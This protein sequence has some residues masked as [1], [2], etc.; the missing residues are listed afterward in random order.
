M[1]HEH[2]IRLHPL[3]RYYAGYIVKREQFNRQR[4][5]FAIGQR[6]DAL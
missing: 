5:T 6:S 3:T 1:Y 2:V 4:R